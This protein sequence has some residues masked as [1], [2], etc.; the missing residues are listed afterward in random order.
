MVNIAVLRDSISKDIVKTFWK[1]ANFSGIRSSK[2]CPSCVL[3][4]IEFKAKAAPTTMSLDICKNCQ[5][6]WFDQG[7][8]EQFPFKNTQ[9]TDEF[10]QAVAIA[11]V[12]LGAVEREFESKAELAID[13]VLMLLKILTRI[14]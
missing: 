2:N 13:I 14:I 4:L 9:T 10:N 7:E 5:L 6:I 8:L 1:T 3:N 12:K 11:K